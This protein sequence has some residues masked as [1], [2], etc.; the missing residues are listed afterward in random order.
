VRKHSPPLFDG[1]VYELYCNIEVRHKRLTL[2]RAKQNVTSGVCEETITQLT[3]TETRLIV[4]FNT[5]IRYSRS[6]VR[7]FPFKKV[8]HFARAIDNSLKQKTEDDEHVWLEI[9][10]WAGCGGR[11]TVIL[12]ADI[13]SS[14]VA[15]HWLPRYSWSAEEHVS[16]WG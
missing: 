8:L 5:A 13:A 9:M 16:V 3:I 10:M 6:T 4:N 2:L 1:A 12:R 14:L 11:R 15:V 7:P